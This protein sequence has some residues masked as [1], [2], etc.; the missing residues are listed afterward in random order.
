MLALLD[1]TQEPITPAEASIAKNAAEKLA[2][3]AKAKQNITVHVDG[4][5]NVAV[6]LPAKVVG[7][8]HEILKAMSNGMPVSIIP[9]EAEL[10]T[11]Q[12]A[13]LLNVSRPHICTLVDQGKLAAHKVGSH[14]RIKY[15][16]LVAYDREAQKGRFA[17]LAELNREA[18]ELGLDD[19]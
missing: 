2:L 4:A 7:M 5:A 14:R 13:D 15:A 10:T 18:R 11:K 19:D 1:Q 6:P 16:D 17:A 8:I 12:A 9:H 3:V